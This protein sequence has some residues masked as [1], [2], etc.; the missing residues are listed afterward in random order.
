VDNLKREIKKKKKKKKQTKENY[1]H[2]VQ[3]LSSRKVSFQGLAI[4]QIGVRLPFKIMKSERSG[5]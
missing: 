5:T 3:G 1:V 4:H 2:I